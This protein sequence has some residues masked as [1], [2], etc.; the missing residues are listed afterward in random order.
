MPFAVVEHRGVRLLEASPEAP[1]MATEADAWQLLEACFSN[2][3][4]RAIVYP[5]NL[6]AAFFDLSSGQAGA[7]L[8]KLRN[9]RVRLAV[10]WP[11]DERRVSSRFAE[12]LAEE[13][14]GRSFNVF[15]SREEALE[16]LAV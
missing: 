12:L 16:W 10:V 11:H 6:P 15:D 3:T 9:Y 4:R 5:A 8:Q 1:V 2:G 13:S 7:V 14:R